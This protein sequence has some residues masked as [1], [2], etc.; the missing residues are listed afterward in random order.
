[1]R[2]HATFRGNNSTYL[3]QLLP[4]QKVPVSDHLLFATSTVKY[5]VSLELVAIVGHL[6]LDKHLQ[7]FLI[8]PKCDSYIKWKVILAVFK[9][10]LSTSFVRTL[11][12]LSENFIFLF[13]SATSVPAVF[14]AK[15]PYFYFATRATAIWR[16]KGAI[17]SLLLNVTC[18]FLRTCALWIRHGLNQALS[19]WAHTC[20]E[21]RFWGGCSTPVREGL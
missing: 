20:W 15:R 21:Q 6:K 1:M 8:H 2:F 17:C 10:C 5:F 3:R 4:W 9:K 19:V 7:E 18:I 16:N 11:S 13:T 12:V 14:E